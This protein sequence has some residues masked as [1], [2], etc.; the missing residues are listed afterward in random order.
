[1]SLYD[2]ANLPEKAKKDYKFV[3]IEDSYNYFKDNYYSYLKKFWKC[4]RE[5]PDIIYEI[6]KYSSPEHLTSSFNNFIINDL[7]CDI[8]HPVNIS[9]TLYYVIEKL[10]ES[11]ISKMKV[12]SDFNKVLIDSNIGYLLEGLLLRKDIQYY[13]S[14]ILTDIIEVY[15]NSEESSKPLL[16]KINDIQ[17]YLVLEK[18]MYENELKRTSTEN[19][20]KEIVKR[21]R[22]E[23]YLFNQLYKMTFPKNT[24]S[25]IFC[26]TLTL[27]KK[28]EII[29]KNKKEMELFVTKYLIDIHKTDL[30]NLINKE[31]SPCIIR[32]LKNNMKSLDKNSNLF[33]N[34][35]LLE[36]I[37]KSENSEKLLFYYKKNFMSAIKILKNILNKFHETINVIPT[38]I[39]YL[40][41]IISD[42]LTNKFKNVDMNDIYKQLGS[43]VFM[44]LF[45]YFFLSLDYYPLINNVL[46][47]ESTKKNLF[48]IFEIFSQLI[49]GEFF[50]SEN[51][52]F[53]YTPFNWFLIENINIFYEV[54]QKLTFRKNINI[55]EKK[56]YDMDKENEFFSYAV[57]FN[58]KI[59]E[60]F[61]D[62]INKNKNIIF[63]NNK[64]KK[65]KEIVD[66]LNN[67][68][69]KNKSS[70]DKNIVNYFLYFD[71]MFKENIMQNNF[72]K[73]S[74]KHINQNI[75]INRNSI[76]TIQS[77]E[78]IKE[79]E[80]NKIISPEIIETKR[81]LTEILLNIN[82][83]DINE[84]NQKIKSNTLKEVLK[85][86]KN[87]YTAKKF[88]KKE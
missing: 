79:K 77:N 45:K 12:I 43:F 21:K 8:F 30:N 76:L 35:I 1:M 71:I 88:I 31:K 27:S 59:F 5:T 9:N 29:I 57:C 68:F 83:T 47:S 10:L 4:L 61:M 24:D 87:Y 37:Q 65:F 2:N 16:F 14:L 81:I 67:N 23:N 63:K 54:C 3:K 44:K 58:M 11:E 66:Y 46:L 70:N 50:K 74:S 6:L 55:K 62:V 19:E 85:T 28:E 34:Q 48:K 18:E 60:T 15:E 38:P 52:S 36:K 40:S 73:K 7:F 80:N 32:Y 41:K 39:I 26:A 75:N 20:R 13:F 69:E 72:Y 25:K 42:L 86:I 22:K 53:Y 84:I 17:D 82:D 64:N 56:I 78:K 51:E 49:S 33:S